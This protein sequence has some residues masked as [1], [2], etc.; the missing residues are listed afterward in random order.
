MADK[1]VSKA[2]REIVSDGVHAI[3]QEIM[4]K[5]RQLHPHEAAYVADVDVLVCSWP[6]LT[7]ENDE[8]IRDV[9]KQFS[10]ASGGGPTQMLPVHLK[11][12]ITCGSEVA[13]LKLVRALRRFVDL[14]AS[15]ALPMELSEFVTAANLIPL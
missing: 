15:G 4:D 10:G 8:L 2:A 1:G 3:D 13:E 6:G 12:A 5:L 11:E 14:C 9:V 7:Q